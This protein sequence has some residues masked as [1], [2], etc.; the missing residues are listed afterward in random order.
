MTKVGF[1]NLSTS[2]V[3]IERVPEEAVTLEE[4]RRNG[5]TAVVAAKPIVAAQGEITRAREGQNT[6]D[7]DKGDPRNIENRIHGYELHTA[8]ARNFQ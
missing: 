8:I 3:S 7:K 6:T 5:R 1:S 4:W 2:D